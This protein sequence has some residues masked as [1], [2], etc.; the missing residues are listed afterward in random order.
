MLAGFSDGCLAAYRVTCID[1]RVK[2]LVISLGLWN[3]RRTLGGRTMR[4]IPIHFMRTVGDR[5]PTYRQ[6]NEA[7]D[8]FRFMGIAAVP[9]LT[10]SRPKQM[11]A[12]S[13]SP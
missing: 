1:R 12:A 9:H 11:A 8:G 4:A 3:E 5:T 6:T 7:S 2:A 10:S 13:A